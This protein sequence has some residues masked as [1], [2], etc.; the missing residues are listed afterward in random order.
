MQDGKHVCQE[1]KGQTNKV[2]KILFH[3]G[4]ESTFEASRNKK[5]VKSLLMKY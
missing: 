3:I 2:I 4:Q 5:R 1:R